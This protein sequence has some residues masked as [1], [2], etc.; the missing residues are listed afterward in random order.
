MSTIYEVTGMTCGHCQAAV[1]AEV[2][3]VAGVTGVHVD[4]AS[5]RVEVQG[6]AE[7]RLAWA[8]FMRGL[9]EERELVAAWQLECAQLS[10]VDRV[11]GRSGE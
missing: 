6:D 8:Q 11:G 7:L 5:G 4:L 10:A 9:E 3:A 1:E 2:G